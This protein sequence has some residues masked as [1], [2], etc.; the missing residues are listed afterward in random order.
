MAEERPMAI[1][2]TVSPAG[3]RPLVATSMT[4]RE[5]FGILRRHTLLI[6]TLTALGMVAG[7][8]T[9]YISK[10]FFPE[11][12][13]STYIQILPPVEIDPMTI[14][15]PQVAKEIQ[16]GHRLSMANLIKQQNTLQDLL[17]RNKV[18]QT[19]WYR[20]RGTDAKRIKYLNSYLGAQA[21]RDAEY[22][23][24]SM[25]AQDSKEA[26]L[27]V[28]E[29][30]DLFVD[31]Q[32]GSKRAEVAEKLARLDEQRTR[33]QRDLDSA[34]KSLSEVRTA[35]DIT[36][37]EKPTGRYFRHTIELQV[38]DLELKAN[39]LTL[40]IKQT[41][42]NIENLEKLATGPITEQIEN[43][44]ETDSVMVL[45]AQQIA[46]QEAE[47][48]G[49][50]TKFGENHKSVRQLQETINQ[51][52]EKRR[53]RK[54]E[55]AEQTR[56]AN[57]A[58][59][60]DNLVV[61]QERMAELGRLREEAAAK[62]RDLDLARAQYEQR[63]VIK[64]E[65]TLMLDSIK[66]QIEKLK[67]MHDDP[68][69]PKVQ[70]VGYAPEPLEMVSSRQWWVPF[71]I[72][73]ILGFLLGVGLSFLIEIL[74]DLVRTQRDVNRFLHIPLLCMVPDAAEDDQ[75]RGIDP[76]RVVRQAPYSMTSESYRQLRTYLKLSVPAESKVLL[77]GSGSA[78]DGKTSVAVNLATTLVAENKRVLL[79]DANFRRPSLQKIFP[80]VGASNS[81]IE[82]G[83]FD[84]GLSSILT[85]QCGPQNAI[86]PSGTEGL[87]IID[88]GPLPSN[89]AEL[90]GSARMEELLKQQRKSY[91]Y[92]IIDSPPILLVSDAKVLAGIADATILVFNAAATKRG[93]AQRTIR[94]L[95]EVGAT[96]VGCVLFATRA[97][98]GGYFE[99]Q[100]RSFQEYQKLQ[101]A[102]V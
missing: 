39:E 35:W 4:P 53:I 12:I 50:L 102:A 30:V 101:H 9:W 83:S 89:P 2:K 26:A 78:G 82:A 56:R 23:E 1:N 88:C 45:L 8:T 27:I 21:N 96:I 15:A 37:L 100:F 32:G 59:A 43:A 6:V 7:G 68:K 49:R 97:I 71:P 87:D 62:K 54:A 11:Y 22:V 19:E 40:G 67:I 86:R 90:L 66:E 65:R 70:R 75:I 17:G 73:T 85:N 13:A 93:A 41:Q 69:T 51:T 91:N 80:K 3:P 98:K 72:G 18:K 33:V 61:L 31:M 5:A 55:I 77:V 24:V 44:I 74:N 63:L 16:Y 99:E 64:D 92:I 34:E 29:M 47:L 14:I 84:F 95:R 10:E 28:N 79:I 57:F 42:A 94:E 36:D 48:S 46:L 20:R 38:D 81:D 76:C 25:T 52:I 60:N 58:N